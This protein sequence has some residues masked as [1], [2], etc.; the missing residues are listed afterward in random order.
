M[1]ARWAGDVPGFSHRSRVG[2]NDCGAPVA[3]RDHRRG[4]H[5]DGLRDQL[6]DLPTQSEGVAGGQRGGM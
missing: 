4:R 5:V 3:G 1:P 2:S 6:A